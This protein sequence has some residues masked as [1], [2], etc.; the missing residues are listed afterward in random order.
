MAQWQGGFSGNSH[1]TKVA[2]VEHSLRLAVAS[3]K[4]CNELE[5]AARTSA[6]CRL[7][8]RL[9]VARL[10]ALEAKIA[11]DSEPHPSGEPSEGST[12][13]RHKLEALLASGVGGILNEFGVPELAPTAAVS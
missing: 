5:K 12:R 11:R 13:Q 2:D 10:K 7:A 3:F 6:V 9:Y 8:R 4:A 1:E